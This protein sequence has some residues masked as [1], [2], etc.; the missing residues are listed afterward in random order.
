MINSLQNH[1]INAPL[2]PTCTKKQST[3]AVSIYSLVKLARTTVKA[4]PHAKLSCISCHFL[5]RVQR[6]F[7]CKCL[8][9][10]DMP[11]IEEHC[12]KTIRSENEKTTAKC[13][14][15][16]LV[17]ECRYISYYSPSCLPMF[18]KSHRDSH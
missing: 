10:S 18:L 9:H 16:F 15:S 13:A 11:F 12:T 8:L 1:H 2:R 7:G 6:V 14:S 3:P 5:L 4:K 17:Y